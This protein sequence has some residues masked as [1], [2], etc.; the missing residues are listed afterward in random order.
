MQSATLP[1]GTVGGTASSYNNSQR[2]YAFTGNNNSFNMALGSAGTVTYTFDKPVN[3]SKVKY[4]VAI[5]NTAAGCSNSLKYKDYN[6]GEWITLISQETTTFNTSYI[7][8]YREKSDISIQATAIEI[9]IGTTGLS[10]GL[11]ILGNAQCWG[12]MHKNKITSRRT[13]PTG[14]CFTSFFSC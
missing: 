1:K 3:I 6:T 7:F 5:N 2:Y 13:T 4:G 8:T 12:T 9:Y 10:T 11:V 14:D